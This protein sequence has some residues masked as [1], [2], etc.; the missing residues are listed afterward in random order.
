MRQSIDIEDS[1]KC[2]LCEECVKISERVM[3]LPNAVKIDETTS[4]FTFTL[5]STGAIKPKKIVLTALKVLKGKLTT[6]RNIF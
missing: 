6:L 1:D 5:E 3:K 4:K 2:N